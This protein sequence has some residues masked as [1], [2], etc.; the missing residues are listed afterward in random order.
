LEQRQQAD[1][2]TSAS[3][4]RAVTP[5]DTNIST[6]IGTGT[7][8]HSAPNESLIDNGLVQPKPKPKRAPRTRKKAVTDSKVSA[9]AVTKDEAPAKR[10]RK[11]A[12]K[13]DGHQP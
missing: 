11:R 7:V 4:L 10:T 1:I 8:K 6:D 13:I 5:P 3:D 12:V 2:A 9:E